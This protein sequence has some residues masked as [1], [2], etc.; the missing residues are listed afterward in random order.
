[1]TANIRNSGDA[2][3]QGYVDY[4][5]TFDWKYFVTGTTRYELTIPSARRLMDRYFDA[6]S[7]PGDVMFWVAEPFE[8]KDG[9]H[10]HALLKCENKEGPEFQQMVDAWQWATGNKALSNANG[11]ISWDKSK[12]NGIELKKYDKRRRAGSYCTKYVMKSRA[13]Y[14]ILI[15]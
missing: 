14:D 3:K 2:T 11:I 9:Q 8:L 13:D 10:T 6:I 1:M 12:W 7:S 5:D 15:K 4:L